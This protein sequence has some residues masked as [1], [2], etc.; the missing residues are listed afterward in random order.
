M[1]NNMERIKQESE[2]IS[3]TVN[4][5]T[6]SNENVEEPTF[7]NFF[8]GNNGTGKSTIASTIK[9]NSSVTYRDK[10]NAD[11][12]Q[13][14]LFND[15]YIRENMLKYENMPGVFTLS[16]EKADIQVQIDEAHTE[17]LD[18]EKEKQE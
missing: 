15:D 14:L 16:K 5:A 2:I 8:F 4:E 6:F 7:I 9:D 18:L 12:Y 11:D 3:I 1:V 13:I 17:R 10:K